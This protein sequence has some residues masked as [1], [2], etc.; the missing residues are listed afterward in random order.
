MAEFETVEVEK[1][2]EVIHRRKLVRR[3]VFTSDPPK[4]QVSQVSILLTEY[5]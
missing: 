3:S 5:R 1:W 2:I 4:C